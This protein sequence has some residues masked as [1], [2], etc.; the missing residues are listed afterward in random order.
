MSRLMLTKPGLRVF[1]LVK[2]HISRPSF[3]RM[4]QCPT[5]YR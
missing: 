5:G 1:A 2:G 4:R 3:Q